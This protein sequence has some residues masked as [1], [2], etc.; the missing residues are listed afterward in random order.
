MEGGIPGGLGEDFSHQ[1]DF[2]P[3]PSENMTLELDLGLIQGQ[4]FASGMSFGK[5][6]GF[7]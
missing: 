7:L 6:D 1:P 3:L 4:L 5:V 2:S